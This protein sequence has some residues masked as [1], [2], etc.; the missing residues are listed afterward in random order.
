MPQF[1]LERRTF[2]QTGAAVGLATATGPI[3]AA[4]GKPSIAALAFDA[5][6][7]FDA[8]AVT[9]AVV[10]TFP[11]KGMAL[12]S[13]WTNKLF[14]LTWLETSAG[15]YSGFAPLA[16][17]ALRHS[18]ITLGIELTDGLRR[19]LVDVFANL[20]VWPDTSD[21][22]KSWRSKGLRL[23]LLSNLSAETLSRNLRNNGL[24]KL[25]DAPISTDACRAFKPAPRAYALGMQHFGLPRERIGFVAFGGWDALG[26]RWFGYPTAWI[27]RL[28]VAAETLD[29]VPDTTAQD[30]SAVDR[31]L[32]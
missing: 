11:E 23:A 17:A 4:I 25:M 15:H 32:G 8:R 30:L 13:A 31:L 2:L 6:T 24:E 29:P 18:A 27:N 21:R 20:P 10:S 26:A 19:D 14:A 16:D 28:G 1:M 22:L 3:Q 7:L 5:F 12:A 9:G